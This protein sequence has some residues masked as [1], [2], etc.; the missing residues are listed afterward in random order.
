MALIFI[1]AFLGRSSDALAIGKRVLHAYP[2]DLDAIAAAARAYFEAGML[3]RAIPLY[4]KALQAD[5]SNLEFR[6]QLARCYLYSGDYQKGVDLL[7]Q[8]LEAGDIANW[9]MNLYFELGQLQKAMEVAE[10]GTRNHPE[11]HVGWYFGG[12]VASTTDDE[13]SS[14]SCTPSSVCGTRPWS[15]R[16]ERW[17]R[18]RTAPGS[19]FSS[20]SSEPSSETAGKR[21]AI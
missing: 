5:P 6:S 13:S 2:E 17:R 21:S 12:C 18:P 16:N 7:T 10:L 20:V 3:D 14:A 11:N 4:S 9:A 1:D 19:C 15:R 8:E